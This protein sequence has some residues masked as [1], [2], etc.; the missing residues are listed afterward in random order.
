LTDGHFLRVAGAL[1]S[2]RVSDMLNRVTFS[3]IRQ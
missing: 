1:K 2:I 3:Y